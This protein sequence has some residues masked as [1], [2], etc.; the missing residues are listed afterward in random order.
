EAVRRALPGSPAEYVEH[1]E[2]LVAGPDG[3]ELEAEWRYVDG[4]VHATTFE[5]L[6]RGLAWAAGEWHRRFEVAHLLSD[7]SLAHVLDAERD[8][9]N[10]L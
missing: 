4:D 3:A 7:P 9:D 5:G 1:G 8:F 10:P 6:A 2:L